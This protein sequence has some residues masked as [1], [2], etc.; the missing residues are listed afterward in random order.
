MNILR[1]LNYGVPGDIRGSQ[2]V[3]CYKVGFLLIMIFS[4]S[5]MATLVMAIS[6]ALKLDE[7][8]LPKIE[9]TK[10]ARVGTGS[11]Y[12]SIFGGICE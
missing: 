5:S 2:I 7:K 6:S 4:A 12:L 8:I 11:A 10:I 9:L 1:D 3:K